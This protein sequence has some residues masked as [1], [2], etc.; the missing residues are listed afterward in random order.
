MLWKELPVPLA[1]GAEPHAYA[2]VVA[3][4]GLGAADP[5]TTAPPLA[6]ARLPRRSGGAAAQVTPHH[7]LP[8]ADSP[9][10]LATVGTARYDK[11]SPNRSGSYAQTRAP[12]R[13]RLG[14]CRMWWRL[15]RLI[16]SPASEISGT[17][18]LN[19]TGCLQGDL[20]VRLTAASD[21]GLTSAANAWTNSE[22]LGFFRP[23]DGSVDLSTG[24][25]EFHMWADGSHDSAI[26]FTG[27][28]TAAGAITGNFTDP[29]PA[30]APIFHFSGG[31]EC[32]APVTGS[33][34]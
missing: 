28:I 9:P 21:G 4:A 1:R 20:P 22:S 32:V 3:P 17:W 24:A 26:L 31:S 23:L 34:R 25:A 2:A 15:Y 12:P 33:R 10:R 19:A 16:Q 18:D 5:P 29:M 27:T 6:R 7:R 8:S 14:A 11:S 30:Y 13:G